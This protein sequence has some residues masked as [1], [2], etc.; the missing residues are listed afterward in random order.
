MVDIPK[1]NQLLAML[2]GAKVVRVPVCKKL[3]CLIDYNEA[4]QT[5][6]PLKIVHKSNV[7]SGLSF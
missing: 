1:N 6:E 3:T 2:R 4:S 5:S 7:S